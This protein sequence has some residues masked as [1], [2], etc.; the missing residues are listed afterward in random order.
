M[1]TRVHW[2]HSKY[3]QAYPVK[4]TPD[5]KFFAGLVMAAAGAAMVMLFKP[6][7]QPATATPGEGTPAAVSAPDGH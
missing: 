2:D 5:W 3:N 1:K 7:D 4:T 6:V